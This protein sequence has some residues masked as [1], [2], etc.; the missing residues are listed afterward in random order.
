M[1]ITT[2]THL[3]KLAANY[4]PIFSQ[5]INACRVPGVKKRHTGVQCLIVV[6]NGLQKVFY[7]TEN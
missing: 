4:N 6:C 2:C 1:Y 7:Q 5:L 3:L